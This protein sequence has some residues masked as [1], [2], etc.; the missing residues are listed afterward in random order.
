MKKIK[1][2]ILIPLRLLQR[3][4]GS[5]KRQFLD[6]ATAWDMGML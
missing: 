4:K 3:V 2:Y 6:L 5:R 1:L